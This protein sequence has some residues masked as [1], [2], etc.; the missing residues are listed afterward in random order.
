MASRAIG[1]G[2]IKAA[3]TPIL[4]SQ[5]FAH[6]SSSCTTPYVRFPQPDLAVAR[7]RRQRPL[8]GITGRPTRPR[9]TSGMG[10][11]TDTLS[12]LVVSIMIGYQASDF[13]SSLDTSISPTTRRWWCRRRPDHD[14]LRCFLAA[15][16]R[17]LDRAQLRTGIERLARKEYGVTVWFS[18]HRLP[19]ACSWRGVG[20][21]AT[22]ERIVAPVDRSR[23]DEIPP[24]AVQR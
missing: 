17:R 3:S 4:E 23:R 24:D 2:S 13:I 18:Q 8:R 9:R 6:S 14:R 11:G 5:R 19:F 15:S 12:R 21:S 10:P 7:S 20:I 22:R 16:E 1:R